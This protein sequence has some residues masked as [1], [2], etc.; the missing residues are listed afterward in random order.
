MCLGTLGPAGNLCADD[1][2]R[3][4]AAATEAEQETSALAKTWRNLQRSLFHDRG[5][6]SPVHPDGDKLAEELYHWKL[7]RQEDPLRRCVSML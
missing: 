6:W 7:D 2:L 5:L 1:Q 3:R 4:A